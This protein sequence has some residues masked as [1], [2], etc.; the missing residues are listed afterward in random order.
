MVL[1]KSIAAEGYVIEAEKPLDLS[2][3][4]VEKL[5]A[6]FAKGRKQIEAEKLRGALNTKPQKLVKFNRTRLVS[7]Q[8][9]KDDR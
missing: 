6:R 7:G 5:R 1:D 8:V 2:K 4:D 9:P 3:I